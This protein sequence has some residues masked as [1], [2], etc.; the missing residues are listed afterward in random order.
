M[1]EFY[2]FRPG[3]EEW[4]QEYLDLHWDYEGN[5]FVDVIIPVMHKDW[6][7]VI[8]FQ[9]MNSWWRLAVA[10]DILWTEEAER[11]FVKIVI[12]DNGI[13]INKEFESTPWSCYGQVAGRSGGRS[14][15]SGNFGVKYRF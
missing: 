13:G 1:E 14:G 9:N 5:R 3:Q 4:L 8:I 15:F 2:E 12:K 6:L 11:E 10:E 7:E